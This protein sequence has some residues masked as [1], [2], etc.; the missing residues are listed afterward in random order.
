V[1]AAPVIS[2]ALKVL[3]LS[4]KIGLIGAPAA[5][6][7]LGIKVDPDAFKEHVDF[8]K[9]L[10][11]EIPELQ[12]GVDS[13]SEDEEHMGRRV[14]EAPRYK[15]GPLDFR[16]DVHREARLALAEMLKKINPTAFA[17]RRWGELE[18]VQYPDDTY[19]WLC[20]QHQE[21]HRIKYRGRG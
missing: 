16:E 9:E 3:S 12:G 7:A 6:G 10:V 15:N 13:F 20:K 14:M 5:V 21:E 4:M 11:G 2:A 17:A 18:R 19:R 8:M 1:K